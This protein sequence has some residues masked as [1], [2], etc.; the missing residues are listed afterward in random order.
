MGP[1]ITKQH[2]DKV[3]G[4]IEK[5]IQEGAKLL[6]DGRGYKSPTHP[7]GYFLGPCVSTA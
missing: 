5:G 6:V 1:L 3:L 4:Y 7:N 2:R